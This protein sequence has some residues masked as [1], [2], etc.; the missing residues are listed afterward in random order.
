MAV[1]IAF[2]SKKAP[3]ALRAPDRTPLSYSDTRSLTMKAVCETIIFG[4]FLVA[5]VLTIY[6]F[7]G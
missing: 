1:V 6:A 5:L 4:C 2:P 3:Q 7:G